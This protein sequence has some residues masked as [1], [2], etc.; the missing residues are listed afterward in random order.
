MDKYNI[1]GK[2]FH[3][4]TYDLGFIALFQEETKRVAKAAED[5]QANAQ[6]PVSV[7]KDECYAVF[8]FF[9]TIL[10]EG[11]SKEIFGETGINVKNIFDVYSLFVEDVANNLKDI[12]FDPK[13]NT[14]DVGMSIP[15]ALGNRSAQE[16]R[17]RRRQA[18]D[19]LTMR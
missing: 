10:R 6:D 8:D 7:I 13:Q 2:E 18:A 15:A 4:E 19:L 14:P 17:E 3:V 9:D 11:A 12:R 1:N 16:E 5:A